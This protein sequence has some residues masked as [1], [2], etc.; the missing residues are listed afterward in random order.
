MRNYRRERWSKW[1]LPTLLAGL[2]VSTAC[3]GTPTPPRPASSQTVLDGVDRGRFDVPDLGQMYSWVI[4]SVGPGSLE[5]APAPAGVDLELRR[6]TG[7]VVA[8]TIRRFGTARGAEA[9]FNLDPYVSPVGNSIVYGFFDGLVSQVRFAIPSRDMDVPIAARDDV[10]IATSTI[11]ADSLWFVS[12]AGKARREAGLW[13]LP[14]EDTGGEAEQALAPLPPSG[15]D[16]VGFTAGLWVTPDQ[17]HLIARRCMSA[18]RIDVLDLDSLRIVG[19]IRDLPV[20]DLYGVTNNALAFDSNCRRPCPVSVYEFHAGAITQVGAFCRTAMM[21]QSADGDILV[22]DGSLKGCDG[23]RTS[24]WTVIRLE[25]GAV[26]KLQVSSAAAPVPSHG[27]RG[28]LAPPDWIVFAAEGNLSAE[29][30]DGYPKL[31]NVVSGQS[32]DVA[33]KRDREQTTPAGPRE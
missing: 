33:G 12:V 13:R 9:F 25:S 28:V 29:Q 20:T 21:I 26:S 19:S 30:P 14:L 32:V 16:D 15:I 1:L 2:A 22:V 10:L 7:E 31:V 6:V 5:S 17:E 23:A 4:R 11:A 27:A 8:R 24:G 3:A 18:C